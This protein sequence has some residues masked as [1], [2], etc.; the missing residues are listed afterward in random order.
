MKGKYITEDCKEKIIQIY[1]WTGSLAVITAYGLT[2]IESDKKI[3]IDCLNLYGSLSI[4]TMCYRATV[5]QAASLEV[6]WFG[7]AVYSII[8]NL[9]DQ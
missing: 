5:W 3:I 1:G 7:I 2:T 6:A 4:G 9:S 8:D